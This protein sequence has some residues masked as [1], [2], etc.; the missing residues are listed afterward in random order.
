MTHTS[1]PV[2]WHI[3]GAIPT[4]L[5]TAALLARHASLAQTHVVKPP[6]AQYWMDV[7]TIS[8]AGMDDMPDMG[9]LGGLMGGMPGMPGMGGGRG[10]FWCHPRHDAGAL[11]GSG[12]EHTA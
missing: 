8:M 6:V 9:A 7:A 2:T 1:Q 5:G 12:G 10:Q 11:A 3:S 4:V